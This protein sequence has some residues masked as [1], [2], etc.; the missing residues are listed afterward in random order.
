ML[1][2]NVASESSTHTVEY[3]FRSLRKPAATAPAA[4]DADSHVVTQSRSGPERVQ[5]TSEDGFF[6]N[7]EAS[8]AHCC[9]QVCVPCGRDLGFNQGQ[10][11]RE[12]EVV[13]RGHAPGLGVGQAHF[14]PAVGTYSAEGNIGHLRPLVHLL[15]ALHAGQRHGAER[16]VG[17]VGG[18]VI[19]S[20]SDGCRVGLPLL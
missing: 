3:P 1:H 6:V 16:R 8:V 11:S 18:R 2:Q 5:E 7:C 12:V 20:A 14:L 19:E 4:A 15:V 13:V 9:T 17:V 10:A